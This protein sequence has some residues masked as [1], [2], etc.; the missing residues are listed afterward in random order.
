MQYF[1]SNGVQLRESFLENADGSKNYFGH[2]G[3]RYSNGYYS[4]DNDS[5]WRY[6]DASGVMA[7]G[8]K[9]INGNTQYFDQDG[10]QVK[11][12]WITGSDGKKRYFDD[13][14]GN[15]AV[16]RF[17]NDKTAI[18]TISIQM[19]LPWLVSKPLMV[20]LIT[21]AKMVSKSKVK[22]LQTMVS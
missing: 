12:A 14:S 18:G 3:N 15:M 9:T 7:V 20:R 10:Y 2:L 1:L 8:L 21:L 19:A 6:F 5:K 22:L 11:G 13:G 16:N 17:A 4:F